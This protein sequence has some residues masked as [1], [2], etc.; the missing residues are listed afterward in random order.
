M[1]TPFD[2]YDT[3]V[4]TIADWLNRQDLTA[5]IPSYIALAEAEVNADD[6]FRVLHSVVRAT[7]QISPAQADANGNFYLPL[8]ADYISMQNLR[9]LE[10]PPPGRID[11]VTQTQMD[12]LRQKFQGADVPKYYAV[13]STEMELLPAPDRQYTAQMV[14]YGKVPPLSSANQTNWLLQN[15]PNI[16]LYGTLLQAAPYLKDDT[17]I[18]TWTTLYEKAANNID[19]SSD[20]GQF[21]GSTMKMRTRRRYR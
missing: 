12:D 8:P 7:A 15:Y 19:V 11:L 5:A 17:R 18:A 1:S 6:R 10:A 4:A 14:Y 9:V 21:S 2:S 16:Y 3:L 20:R 13:L